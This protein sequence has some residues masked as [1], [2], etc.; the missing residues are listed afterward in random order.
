M[1]EK[2][3]TTEELKAT[4]ENV[5]P[6]LDNRGGSQRPPLETFPAKPQQ[7][8]GPSVETQPSAKEAAEAVERYDESSDIPRKGMHSP[9]DH[10][11]GE[12]EAV[13]FDESEGVVTADEKAKTA[14][15]AAKTGKDNK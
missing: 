12:T 3:D 14:A 4:E 8:D 9:G 2:K 13:P 11:L 6:R 15:D 7:I 1:E 5:D 10:G